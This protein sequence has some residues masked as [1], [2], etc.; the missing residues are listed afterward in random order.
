M[1]NILASCLTYL[2]HFL[3][4]GGR[5]GGRKDRGDWVVLVFFIW[6]LLPCICSE[7]VI[8]GDAQVIDLCLGLDL[9]IILISPQRDPNLLSL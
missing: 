6:V 8:A 5:E 4:S 3:A 2:V 7:V 9:D 1:L